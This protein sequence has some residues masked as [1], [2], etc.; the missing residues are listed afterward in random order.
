MR[1]KR[2]DGKNLYIPDFAYRSNPSDIF[3]L[4]GEEQARRA[5]VCGFEVVSGAE[6]YKAN[7]EARGGKS[8]RE[9]QNNIKAFPG[10]TPA[11]KRKGGKPDPNFKVPK[12]NAGK[13]V[14]K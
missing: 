11:S 10:R 5:R 3:I 7:L 4:C 12:G 1:T 8:R 6:G 13:P 9:V 2:Q 14:A